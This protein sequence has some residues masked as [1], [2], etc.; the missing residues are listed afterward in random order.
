[1]YKISGGNNKIIWDKVNNKPLAQ[2][3]N[4]VFETEDKKIA[5]KLK[6]LDY[7]VEEI[8]QA[9]GEEKPADG[10]EA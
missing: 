1:M 4:G 2:F 7:V 10:Q 3:N 5:D 9:E 6:K 8:K